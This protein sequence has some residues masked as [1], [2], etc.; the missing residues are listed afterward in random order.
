MKDDETVDSSDATLDDGTLEIEPTTGDEDV[1]ADLESTPAIDSN[2]P[3]VE[4][5]LK[6]TQKALHEK[7]EELARLK[8]QVDVLTKTETPPAKEYLDDID[9][10]SIRNDP[11]LA[12]GAIRH[13]RDEVV[14]VLRSR[15]AHYASELK[16]SRVADKISEYSEE[17]AELRQDP[18]F[19]GLDDSVLLAIAQ[20][21][22]PKSVTRSSGGLRGKPARVK[23]SEP[24]I[25][26]SGLFKQ[27]YGDQFSDKKE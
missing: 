10:D 7:A 4:K 15:D 27:I 22:T 23:K 6:D 25:K 13:L 14:D 3:N 12:I 21:Q 20:K 8:G 17:V 16:K 2:E 9:E 19:A 11:S 5:R 26:Q 24:D 1:E 18:D